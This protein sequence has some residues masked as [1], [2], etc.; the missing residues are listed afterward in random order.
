LGIYKFTISV[1]DNYKEP[2]ATDY[3]LYIEVR[4]RALPS[5]FTGNNYLLQTEKGPNAEIVYISQYQEVEIEFEE[6]LMPFDYRT[7]NEA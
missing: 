1:V 3:L 6:E 2:K 7:I 4:E 5:D